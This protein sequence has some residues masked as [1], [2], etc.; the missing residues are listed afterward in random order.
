[1]AEGNEV[2]TAMCGTGSGLS[3]IYSSFVDG[4]SVR[5]SRRVQNAGVSQDI[6]ITSAPPSYPSDHDLRLS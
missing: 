4:L 2:E 6:R 1:M 3:V 5:I